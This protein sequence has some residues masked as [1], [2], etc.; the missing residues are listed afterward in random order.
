LVL[1]ILDFAPCL[2]TALQV[3]WAIAHGVGWLAHGKSLIQ[4]VLELGL[5][6][7]QVGCGQV[8]DSHDDSP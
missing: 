2:V 8:F 5:K 6:V 7:R 4:C 1:K 3:A